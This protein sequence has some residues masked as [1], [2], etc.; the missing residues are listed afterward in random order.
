MMESAGSPSLLP[1]GSLGLGIFT[2]ALV[3]AIFSLPPVA[4]DAS[5]K[6]FIFVIGALAA[7]RYSWGAVHFIRAMIYKNWVFPKYRRIADHLG[8]D[9]MPS[10]IYLLITSFRIDGQT[11]LEVF[12]ATI[13]EA[14]ACDIPATIVASIV[15]L[16]D[17]FLIKE[18]FRELNPPEHVKLN[19]VRIPGT[20]KRDGLAQGFRA[21]SRDLPPADAVVAV[22]DGDSIV[23]EGLIRRTACF[24]KMMPDIGAL[25]TDE[26]CDVKGSRIIREWHDLR[27][28]QRQMLMSSMGLSKRVLTLTGRMSM[29]RGEIITHPDFIAQVENDYLEH[30]RFG[31]LKFLTGDDKSSWYWVLK[32]GWQM[33]YVPDVKIHTVEH[34]PSDNFLK[35]STQLMFRWFGNMLRTNER[36]L[37]V[38]PHITGFF[39]WW[40][41]LDQ[42]ISM[43]TSLSGP[44]F[45]TMLCLKYSLSFL[46]VYLVWIGFTRLIMT[47]MLL[48][49]RTQTSWMYPFLLYYNQIY[50]SFI[51]TYVFFRLDRQSWTRQKTKLV[52]GQS[53]LDQK[54]NGFMSATLHTLSLL[55]FIILIGM[56]AGVI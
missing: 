31:H 2:L 4:L 5:S 10:H 13:R 1:K 29:F 7:W 47:F 34:P 32:N 25:T 20:G 27:F 18:I 9:V 30:W 48:T 50:G 54:L 41:L 17:E 45:V 35:A 37:D 23:E 55:V 38:P 49:T 12:R 19:L 16:A 39:T 15:E 28:A 3:T 46:W 51:K 33:L 52:S 26:E 14:I 21:I 42:R 43:W 6:Q 40:C 8:A 56:M 36:A 44:V 24:F 22:I 53:A 11:S